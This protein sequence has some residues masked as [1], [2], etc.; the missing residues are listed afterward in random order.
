MCPPGIYSGICSELGTW[1]LGS[2]LGWE[3]KGQYIF[4]L[5]DLPDVCVCVCVCVC[6]RART[7][8]CAGVHELLVHH[9][10][11][12]YCQCVHAQSLSWHCIVH[13]TS[14]KA[15]PVLQ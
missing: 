9:K 11:A 2:G 5:W 13:T 12:L 3:G 14:M 1:G 8:E 15:S 10:P 7:H 6:V 4:F